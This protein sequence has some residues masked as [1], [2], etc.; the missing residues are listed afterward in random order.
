MALSRLIKENI[1]IKKNA[2]E[3]IQSVF[4]IEVRTAIWVL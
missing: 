3:E 2:P 1:I 4:F